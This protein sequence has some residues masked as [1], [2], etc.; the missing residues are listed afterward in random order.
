VGGGG[1]RMG[2]SVGQGKGQRR[3]GSGT[4]GQAGADRRR[5]GLKAEWV[6]VGQSGLMLGRGWDRGGLGVGLS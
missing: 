5:T 2:Q 1:Q 4:E 6:N 3:E